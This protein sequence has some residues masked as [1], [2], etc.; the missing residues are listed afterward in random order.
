L[1]S[2]PSL[3]RP[4]TEDP[5]LAVGEGEG[6]QSFFEHLC[7]QRKIDGIQ[8]GNTGGKGK[9]AAFLKALP[10]RPGYEKLKGLLIVRD[11]DEAPDESFSEA[12]AEI[13]QAKS[14][15]IPNNPMAPKRAGREGI[16]VMVMMLPLADAGVNSRGCLETLILPA[17]E[18]SNQAIMQC[19]ESYWQ[20]VPKEAWSKSSVDKLRV[21][22]IISAAWRDDPNLSLKHI[23][24]SE[25]DL[26]SLHHPSFDKIEEVLR[27]FKKRCA[28]SGYIA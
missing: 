21:R 7:L 24:R 19:V 16:V 6:D 18:N 3:G 5:I 20:C 15:P 14:F 9:L 23:F 27:S 26:I 8:H 25:Y 2:L 22:G 17:L 10:S 13:K 12:R 4:L 11:N 1:P 28:E